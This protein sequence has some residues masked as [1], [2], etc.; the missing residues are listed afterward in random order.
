MHIY[1][2]PP[3]LPSLRVGR[4]GLF[5]LKHCALGPQEVLG[6]WQPTRPEGN[7][8]SANSLAFRVGLGLVS[9]LG[10]GLELE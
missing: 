4:F 1:Q 8:S 10:L 5:H 9:G 7:S 6:A 3:T 2:I